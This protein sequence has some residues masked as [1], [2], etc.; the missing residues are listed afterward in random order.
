MLQLILLMYTK[1]D[2]DGISVIWG[3]IK[4]KSY[5]ASFEWI[6]QINKTAATLK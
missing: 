6:I 5:T 1:K 4:K 2:D 3:K